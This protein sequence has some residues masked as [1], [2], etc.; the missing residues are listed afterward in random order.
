MPIGHSFRLRSSSQGVLLD[1]VTIRRLEPEAGIVSH[2]SR[3]HLDC[4][5]PGQVVLRRRGA[6]MRIRSRVALVGGIPITIAAAIAVIAWLL[7]SAAERTRDGAVLAGTV[8]RDLLGLMV[9]R[10]DYIRARASERSIHLSQFSE[11]AA[12]GAANL[13]SLARLAREPSHRTVVT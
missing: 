12:K 1:E 3:P 9:E 11:L 6:R 8:Y 4:L 5:V 10:D 7:L 13:D 2:A